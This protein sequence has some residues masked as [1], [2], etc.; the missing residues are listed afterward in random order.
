MAQQTAAATRGGDES[1]EDPLYVNAKQYHRILK[2]RQARAKLEAENKIPKNRK[3][4]KWWW[5]SYE[6]KY[7]VAFE[8]GD[9]RVKFA[10][11]SLKLEKKKTFT[12]REARFSL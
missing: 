1:M 4:H 6:Y 2:R 10:L 7:G 9:Q 11:P 3:V 12:V 8:R 5:S